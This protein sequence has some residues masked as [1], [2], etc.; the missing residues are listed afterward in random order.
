MGNRHGV[1]ITQTRS[2][3]SE[4]RRT[5]S[6]EPAN[7]YRTPQAPGKLFAERPTKF[8]WVVFL[9][10]CSTSWMMYLHRY[11][12]SMIKPRLSDAGVSESELGMLDS[13]FAIC[14]VSFQIPSGVIAD[15]F[16]AHLYL[17][18]AI[19]VWSLALAMHT[20]PGFGPLSVGRGLMGA[21]Q[22]G[23]FAAISRVTRTWF[24]LSVRTTV[25]G[26]MGVFAGRIG[27]MS[28]NLIYGTVML[29]LLALSW[30]T[31]ALILAGAGIGLALLFLV[32]FR[33]SP[34]ESPFV[35]EAEAELIEASESAAS[36]RKMPFNEMFRRMSPRSIA[37]L[38][39]VTLSAFLSTMADNLYS[40]WIPLFLYQV[41]QLK[42][43]EMGIYSA[44]PLLGGAIGGVVGGYF[45]DL[46]L[47]KLTKR[48]WARSLVGLIGKCGAAIWLGVALLF[49]DNP[50]A[51]CLMLVVVKFFADMEV[52]TRWGTVTD[53]AGP[54]TAS[55]FS[56]NNSVAAI[57]QVVA[58]LL[59]G[60]V[61]QLASWHMVFLIAMG[62]YA[63]GGLTWLV[64]NS[65]IPL[66]RED[67]ETTS[68]A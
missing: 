38:L 31:G 11:V 53:I 40:N 8:R 37:N 4:A 34:R 9:L 54:A 13:V 52:A 55:V 66:I 63:L 65:T 20:I 36:R 12:F 51:F 5:M 67:D 3:S 61:A 28:A 16:G 43:T 64:T 21:A 14:Y 22:A 35:N 23:V 7:P 17:T 42:F 18:A 57:G 15:V 62:I 45:N 41:Y 30:Q 29:G 44:L 48:R 46:L 50:Y 68:A 25:Q 49:Y 6:H 32:L 27:G 24:P 19:A 58:P 26:F 47:R 2:T 1:A 39:A 60:F 59:F 56:F 33:S 10:G